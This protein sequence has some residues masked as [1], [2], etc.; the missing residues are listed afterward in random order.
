MSHL[1]NMNIPPHRLPLAYFAAG[2][3][4]A[5][6]CT[7][8][9]TSLTTSTTTKTI[10][11][12]RQPS[13]PDSRLAYDPSA[14]PGARQVST[15]HGSLRVNEFGPE[16]GRKVLLIHGIST[17]SP[18][19]AP[20]AEKL[21]DKGCRVLLY[22]L[23]GRGWS[24][25]VS[26]QDYDERLYIS[27]IFYVLA[28]SP[29]AWIP[30]VEGDGG[31]SVMGYSMG[32]G[33]ANALV[34]YFPEMVEDLVLLAPVGLMREESR[35]WSTKLIF[36]GVLPDVLVKYLVKRRLTNAPNLRTA[37]PAGDD[38][39]SGEAAGSSGSDAP[40]AFGNRIDA[41]K[42]VS[43]QLEEHEAFLP[44]FISS[45]RFAPLR[46]QHETWELIG[47]RLN[48]QREVKESVTDS[49]TSEERTAI[50]RR[51]FKSGKVLMVVGKNDDVIRTWELLPDAFMT[52]GEQNLEVLELEAGHEVPVTRSE[53]IVEWI[54]Q[55]WSA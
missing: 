6:L 16:S 48:A 23:L 24:D 2:A 20:I 5:A 11:S 47:K 22:D 9:Y 49:L 50:E 46:G 19:L 17:P 27:Q 32:G 41:A 44:A 43:W 26:D 55:Y 33:I 10:I 3:T 1:I 7:L 53:E 30:G 37:Q 15:P 29:I 39:V 14:L 35:T 40:V 13:P 42:I 31:F 21:A 28:S 36:S 34:R 18:A 8:L 52:V 38:P 12:P 25:G 4:S 51:G 45:M 54:W